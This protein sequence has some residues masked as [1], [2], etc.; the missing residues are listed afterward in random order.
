MM[1]W[2]ISRL[3]FAILWLISV[4][5]F[6]MINGFNN[7]CNTDIITSDVILLQTVTLIFIIFQVVKFSDVNKLNV[8]KKENWER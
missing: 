2:W 5:T 4:V 8:E 6:W 3:D 1:L 7:I